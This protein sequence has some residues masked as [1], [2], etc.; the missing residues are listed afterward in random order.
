MN[1]WSNTY[2]ANHKR[3]IKLGI[4]VLSLLLFIASGFNFIDGDISAAFWSAGYGSFGI[5]F[6]LAYDD[7]M[8]PF[9]GTEDTKRKMSPGQKR[10][11]VLAL[12][13]GATGCLVWYITEFMKIM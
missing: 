10:F 8:F 7:H 9:D 12:L 13:L 1:H 6:A 5:G 4:G 2:V 3:T 11:T